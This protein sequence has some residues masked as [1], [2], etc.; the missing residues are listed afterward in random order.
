MPGFISID[1]IES[2]SEFH[3]S[4]FSE[5]ASQSHIF[6]ESVTFLKH[7][8]DR[9]AFSQAFSHIMSPPHNGVVGI[10]T[11]KPAYFL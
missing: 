8:L 9:K 5:Y 11:Q 3:M 7:L 10:F 1:I 4:V 2:V 6:F